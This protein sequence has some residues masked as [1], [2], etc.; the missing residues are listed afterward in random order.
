MNEYRPEYSILQQMNDLELGYY[1]ELCYKDYLIRK[2][3]S[4]L[5]TAEAFSGVINQIAVYAVYKLIP[6]TTSANEPCVS[7]NIHHA[8]Y[9]L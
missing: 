8:L 4:A 5:K 1:I 9:G 2:K 3:K 7:A 6:A